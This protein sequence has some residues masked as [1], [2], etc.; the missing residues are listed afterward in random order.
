[1]T[2]ELGGWEI[3]E[4][5]YSYIRRVLPAGSTILE[6]GSG[7]GTERLS[8][9]YTMYSVEHDEEFVNKY[10]SNYI[11]VPLKEHK[12]VQNHE[13]VMWYDANLLREELRQVPSYDLLLIDGPPKHRAGFVKYFSLF[14]STTILVFD[15]VNRTRDNKVLLSIAS[16]LRAPYVMYGAGTE[17]LFGVI[18]DPNYR[19]LD[20]G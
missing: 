14:D 20:H 5:L 8:E 3:T 9:H 19:A 11:S 7:F 17:K 15:D 10:T 16:K 1:M 12:A 13:G 2:E 4:E 18:N 6:L